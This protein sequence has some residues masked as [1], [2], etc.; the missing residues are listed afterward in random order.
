MTSKNAKETE[1]LGER[2]ARLLKGGEIIALSGELGSGKTTFTKGIARGLGVDNAEYVNSPSFVLI[3]EYSGRVNLYHFDLYRLD[4]L[5]EI[6][7]IG[8]QEYLN[9]NGVVVIEWAQK[10]KELLPEEFLKIS[11]KITGNNRRNFEFEG[12]GK[13]YEDIVSRYIK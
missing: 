7:Y 2:L 5:Y 6:E 3:K 11:I 13:R 8:I 1:A 9:S 10:L 4:N 12:F